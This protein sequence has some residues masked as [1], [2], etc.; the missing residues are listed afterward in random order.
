VPGRLV[1]RGIATCLGSYWVY[2][3]P[4]KKKVESRPLSKFWAP[5][6]FFLVNF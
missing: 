4:P 6:L 2:V 3:L 1:L 5:P